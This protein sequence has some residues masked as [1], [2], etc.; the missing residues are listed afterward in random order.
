M[1]KRSNAPSVKFGLRQARILRKYAVAVW[2][3]SFV[4]ILPAMSVARFA[5]WRASVDLP[6]SG[7]DLPPGEELL[8]SVQALDSVIEPLGI[9]IVFGLLGHWL[10]T[11][12]WHAGAVQWLTWNNALPVR[13]GQIVGLGILSFLRYFKLSLTALFA[14]AVSLAL[15]WS[16]I[17]LLGSRAYGAMNE[18]V[19]IVVFG[20][21]VMLSAMLI[22]TI[23]TVTM[24]AAWCLGEVGAQ[25]VLR[26]WLRE[27]LATL[28]SPWLSLVP[29]LLLG[30]VALFCAV[31]PF[32]LGWLFEPFSGGPVG[33]LT[34][35]ALSLLQAFCWLALFLSYAPVSS[36]VM[37][38]PDEDEGCDQ[39]KETAKV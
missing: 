34:T 35:G 24:R 36:A 39:E 28:R 15:V 17:W 10:W 11:I 4:V 8:I 18:R 5:V 22:I 16:P 32:A 9:A 33:A 6:Q 27:V 13:L 31:L 20:C 21:G 23:W 14:G 25:S 1:V 38:A 37:I 3:V 7:V 19:I 12:L 2:L 30:S 26:T 29:L